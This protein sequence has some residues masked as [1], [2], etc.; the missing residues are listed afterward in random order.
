MIVNFDQT[1][2]KMVPVSEWT[3]E[4]QGTKQIDVVGLDDKREVTVLLA[5]S[6][7]GNLLPPQVIYA[8]KTRRCHPNAN[9]PDGWNVTRFGSHWSTQDTMVEYVDMVLAPYMAEQQQILGLSS[10]AVGLCIFDVFAAHRCD[11]FLEKLDA[12]GIKH[13][14]VPAGCTGSL[15]PLDVS[16]N[17]PFKQHLKEIFSN[18]YAEQVKNSL[19]KDDLVENVKVDLKTSTIK[20][21][22][23][24]WL[25]KNHSWLAQ[26]DRALIRGWKEAEILT[27][28]STM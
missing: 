3:L 28:L 1:G 14:F 7:S 17:E 22:H 8:G 24:Q 11:C 12:C 23:F 21:I 4:I 15:Q 5:V 18:W 26:Q 19:E 16:I 25:I 10:D 9:V 13:V 20:P 27:C 6:L 2:T